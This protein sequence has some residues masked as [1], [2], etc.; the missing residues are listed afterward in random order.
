[1]LNI[2]RHLC[3]SKLSN[4]PLTVEVARDAEAL[5]THHA[6]WEDLAAAAQ[7][8]NPFYEP[9]MVSPALETL[10]QP[11]HLSFY[12]VYS[13]SQGG[14]DRARK[15]CGLFPLEQR[16]RFHG[17]PIAVCRLW[18]HLHCFYCAPLVRPG[19]AG[20]CLRALQDWFAA[21]ETRSLL[22]E[23]PQVPAEGK[24][25]HDLLSAFHEQHLPLFVTEAH[26]RPLLVAGGDADTYLKNALS[27]DRRK[28]L[29]KYEQRLAQHGKVEYIMLEPSDDVEA[30]IKD[31]LRLEACG[32]KGR[33]GT[34]LACSEADK[35]FFSQIVLEA[36]HRGRLKMQALRVGGRSIA[37]LCDFLAGDGAFAF[38]VAFDEAYSAYSPGTLLEVE[39][40]RV[41]HARK[42]L[43]TDSCKMPGVAALDHLWSERRAIQN[44][45]V[46]GDHRAAALG[47]AAMPLLRYL[48]GRVRATCA[49]AG[50]WLRPG[51]DRR[52]NN[53]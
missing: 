32:W 50:K 34:A 29:R 23:W 41:A 52:G 7:E 44:L 42:I 15:L 9:W 39:G 18:T 20:P 25:C 46:A 3:P 24:L 5:R 48:K 1:M 4:P 53:S 33:E 19:F 26:T 30:W 12:L 51:R 47:V 37:A 14:S 38:K 13:A 35:K 11:R 21:H 10:G 17:L 40:I 6:A 8:A 28:K 49:A 36:F 16:T 43:W 22:W 31:F 27:G 45:L 2:P